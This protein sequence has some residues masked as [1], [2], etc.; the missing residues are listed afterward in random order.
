MKA[1]GRTTGQKDLKQDVSSCVTVNS[2]ISSER[3]AI[4]GFLKLESQAASSY[5]KG[6]ALWC[7]SNVQ[8]TL[9]TML[10]LLKSTVN[11]VQRRNMVFHTSAFTH[12]S[13]LLVRNRSC[14]K[15]ERRA[16]LQLG[17]KQESPDRTIGGVS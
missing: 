12:L 11:G 5:N 14:T 16:I 17:R 8:L 15:G 2:Q 6:I 9:N 10:S 4:N 7:T 1:W 13:Y 3:K